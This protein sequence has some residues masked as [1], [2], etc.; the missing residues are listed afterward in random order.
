M[1]VLAC[2]R[3]G[4]RNIMCDRLSH[5]YGYICNECWNELVKSGFDTDIKVFMDSK[6]N[7]MSEINEKMAR[8]RYTL[9]FPLT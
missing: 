6:K 8:D 2:N 5:I 3:N 1:G 9:V 7:E 4:C